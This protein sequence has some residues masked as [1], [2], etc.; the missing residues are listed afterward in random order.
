MKLFGAPRAK[1][2]ATPV[3]GSLPLPQKPLYLVSTA[4]HPNYGDELITRA[5]LEYLA[6]RHP[7]RTVWLDCPH[8]GRASHLFAGSHPRLR[9]TSTLWELALGSESHDPIADAERVTRIVRDLGSPRFDAGLRALRGVASIHL[10]GGGYVNGVWQ[11]NLGLLSAIAAVR[12]EFGV[13]AFATGLDVMPLEEPLASWAKD[14]LAAFA[15]VEARDEATAEAMGV[16]L[17]LDDAFLA[18]ALK[19]PLYDRRPTPDRMVLVQGDLREWEDDA[20]LGTIDGFLAGISAASVGFA[21]SNPP[22]DHH[23]RG[24]SRPDSRFYTFG[25]LWADGLPARAGQKWLT[26]RIHA[27]LLAAAAGAAG[28]VLAGRGGHYDAAHSALLDLGTGWT[29]VKAGDPVCSEDATVD[30]SFADKAKQ[31]AARKRH[32]ADRL[33]PVA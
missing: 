33:Y 21:E 24:L 11:D 29:V 20:V 18:L 15:S 4:G 2:P 8:P 1:T 10:L 31:L 12:E 7:E 17:G 19:R 23:F 6:A 22:D 5:W 25:G 26:S 30:P 28:L 27:H 32:Q 14:R 9:T 13:P 3:T 16:G